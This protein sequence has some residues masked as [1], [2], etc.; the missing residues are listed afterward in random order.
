MAENRTNS[1][2]KRVDSVQEA[3]SEIR[4]ILQKHYEA[5]ANM[6]QQTRDIL[7]ESM[8]TQA[9]VSGVQVA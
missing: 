4:A 5:H 8:A 6:K 9:A 2:Q 3:A 1:K 7:A